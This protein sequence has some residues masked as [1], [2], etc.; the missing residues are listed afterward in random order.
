MARIVQT[1]RQKLCFLG[2]SLTETI[3]P[4]NCQSCERP[5]QSDDH[6][7]CH[8]CWASLREA[9][10]GDYCHRCGAAVG[11]YTGPGTGCNRCRNFKLS[12]EQLARVGLHRGPL[13]D[14][15]RG[16][17]F[18]RQAHLAKL[19]GELLG[20][21]VEGAGLT[22]EFDV[23]TPVP[24]HWWRTCCRGYNQAQLLAERLSSLTHRPVRR[25]LR[26]VRWTEPQ[27]HLSRTARLANVRGAFALRRGLDVQGKRVLLIDDVLTTGAT[28]SEA[29]S[30]LRRAGARVNVAVVAVAGTT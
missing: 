21:A 14:M 20:L 2:Q 19:L 16:F 1:C 30:V 3:L 4:R 23:I 9:I 17:K 28:A 15:A 8:L 29:A 10:G 26:R 13:A 18:A 22:E 7:L 6:E 27:T 12:Y 5:L 25:L 24:L 11:P